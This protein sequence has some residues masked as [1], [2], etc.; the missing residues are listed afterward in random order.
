MNIQ[1]LSSKF[2]PNHHSSHHWT[3]MGLN[4]DSVLKR[5]TQKDEVADLHLNRKL[6]W[7]YVLNTSR[8]VGSLWRTRESCYIELSPTR[9]VASCAATE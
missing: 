2:F 8:V 9:E 5:A 7:F 6:I 1:Q 3:L 4:I